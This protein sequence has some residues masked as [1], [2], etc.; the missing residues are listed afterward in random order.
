MAQ[1]PVLIN[2]VRTALRRVRNVREKK[3]F[4]GTTF[5]V[6]GKM[7][8]SARESRLMCRVDPALHDDLV[9]R[10]GIRAMKMNGREYKGF[11]VVPGTAV[12]TARALSYW[13]D[14]ALDFNKR[15]K[16]SRTSR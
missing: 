6:N 2:K 14:L 1:D 10:K 7:C 4:G 5:M 15:A 12:S 16:S 11:V 8:I 13:I 9:K 3:M